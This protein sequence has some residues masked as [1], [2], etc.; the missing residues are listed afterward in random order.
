MTG[1]PNSTSAPFRPA[2]RRGLKGFSA[3]ETMAVLIGLALCATGTIGIVAGVLMIAVT[4]YQVY[5]VPPKIQRGVYVGTCPYCDAEMSAT[6]Y[7][8]HVDCPECQRIVTVRDNRF[9]AS[10]QVDER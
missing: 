4:L 8:E 10:A 9:V 3:I 2:S 1:E 5:F 7:H 6:H